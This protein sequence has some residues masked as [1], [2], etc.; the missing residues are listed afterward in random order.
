M[1]SSL[2]HSCML[3]WIVGRRTILIGYSWT[4]SRRGPLTM[5]VT[6]GILLGWVHVLSVLHVRWRR[7]PVPASRRRR[8]TRL[9]SSRTRPTTTPSAMRHPTGDAGRGHRPQP[10][11]PPARRPPGREAYPGDVFYLHSRLLE[12]AARVN[13]E[14]V[15]KFTD[16]KVTGKTGS[17]TALPIIETLLGDV[18]AY[19]PTN[20]ISITDGQIY[21]EPDLFFA[22]VRPAVNV[23]I[24][25]SRVGGNAQVKAMKKLGGTLRLDLAAFAP[26]SQIAQ[27]PFGPGRGVQCGPVLPV[28][29]LARASSPVSA[30]WTFRSFCSSSILR[31]SRADLESSTTRARLNAMA[32]LCRTLES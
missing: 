27:Q 22:G 24:S 20:V 18:S 3:A 14:Y 29:H 4:P 16:G 31:A 26:T 13:E 7:R 1:I 2:H 32:Q 28:Q 17:L 6:S 9:P 21:L 11:D 15:E 10:G 25:V 12:R 23:G 30:K 5:L 8:R 19:V